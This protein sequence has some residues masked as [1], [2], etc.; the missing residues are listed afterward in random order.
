MKDG[1][2]YEL[3]SNEETWLTKPPMKFTSNE[4]KKDLDNLSKNQS[5]ESQMDDDSDYKMFLDNVR[6]EGSHMIYQGKNTAPVVYYGLDL[7]NPQIVDE[8]SNNSSK[9]DSNNSCGSRRH[10]ISNFRVKIMKILS[11]PYD[12]E[13]HE[14]LMKAITEYKPKQ[15]R[16]YFSYGRPKC[17]PSKKMKKSLLDQH[18]DLKRMI[19]AAAKDNLKQLNL[20][21]G[22]FF[23]LE[24]LSDEG[25]F[26]PWTNKECVAVQPKGS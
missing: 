23:W 25:S 10:E 12:E 16:I 1:S 13:E 9:K 4:A 24:N 22:F 5:T 7:S 2:A 26:S 3:E 19:R 21:R 8:A 15:K 17:F 11:K 6:F 18:W 20:L 14:R